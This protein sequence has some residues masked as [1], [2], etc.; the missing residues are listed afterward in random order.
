MIQHEAVDHPISGSGVGVEDA[1][2]TIEAHHVFPEVLQCG[3]LRPIPLNPKSDLDENF[4]AVG[5][6][7]QFGFG[8]TRMTNKS[9]LLPYCG[10]FCVK[11]PRHSENEVAKTC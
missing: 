8:T 5:C 3:S 9:G 7:I 10:Q 1:C 11:V 2:Y 6:K 4:T